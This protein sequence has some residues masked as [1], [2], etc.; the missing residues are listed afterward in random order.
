MTNLLS[1]SAEGLR[2]HLSS[3]E[4]L[5]KELKMEVNT[6]KTKISVIG[7]NTNKEPFYWKGVTLERVEAYKYLGVWIT[8]D[9]SYGRAKQH[10][11]NQGKRAVL[12]YS[13]LEYSV[14]EYSRLQS[15]NY[16]IHLF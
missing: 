1:T 7:K 9:G 2:R 16:N 3:L 11:A 14:L 6:A 15:E 13:V 8:T 10:F 4:S 12:K 5:C